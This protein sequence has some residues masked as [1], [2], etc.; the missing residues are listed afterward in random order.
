MIAE[1]IA[2]LLSRGLTLEGPALRRKGGAG[3]A[4]GGALT[5]GGFAVNAPTAGHYVAGT[6]Y[7]LRREA[8]GSALLLEK[9]R[10]VCAVAL[11]SAPAFYQE[12]TAQGVPFKKIALLHGNDCLATTT[13]QTCRFWSTPWRCRFCGI[14][15]SLNSGQTIRR[16]SPRDLAQVAAFARQHDGVRHVVLTTGCAPKGEE[17]GHLAACARAIKEASGLPIHG[18]CL[19][20]RDAGDMHR[21]KEAGV[22]TL[23][24]HIESW[25]EQVLARMAP[26]KA[27]LGKRGFIRAW[28]RAVEIFG[29]GQVSSF[30]IAGLGESQKSLLSGVEEMADLGVFPFLVPLRPIP[31]SQME[32]AAP[33]PAAQMIELYQ[34]AAR[35][36]ASRGLASGQS[37]AGCVRCGACSAL[38]AFEGP[39]P[40]LVCHRARTRAELEQALAVRRQVF[41]EEQGMFAQSDRDCDDPRSIH[42]VAKLDSEVVGT[43]RVY[44]ISDT[45]DHWI[46]GRLAVA[47][48]QRAGGAGEILVRRAMETVKNL[49]CTKFTASI[50]QGNVPFFKRLGWRSL[51]D[52]Q[53]HHGRPHQEMQADLDLVRS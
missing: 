42:L 41:V 29:P 21:L 50:Q 5:I 28:R 26:P 52:I 18:Q 1:T 6:P 9:G 39:A 38:A 15:L 13:L 14:E 30:L 8:D 35:I 17:V 40:G 44:P 37:M 19:P 22:D 51:G 3:P 4:E 33:P 32:K 23:G 43:V 53:H 16:K 7:S 34:K 12:V 48:G 49:G 46:G 20:M 27:A 47:A 2:A 11:P 24:L 36:L 10:E 25:D 45:K 31:G